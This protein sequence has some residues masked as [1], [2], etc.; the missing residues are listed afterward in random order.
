MQQFL[1]DDF[2]LETRFARTLYH[3]YA[4]EMPIFDYH[5][6]LNPHDIAADR[7]FDNL[8]QVW[9]AGDHY[10]WR[11][12]RTN[13][14]AERLITGDAGD[15]EKFE[16][17][18][19]TV[20]YTL[21]NPL[22][23]WTHM[24]LKAV[25]GIKDLL[26]SPETA[27]RIYD[28]C[29]ELLKGKEYSARSLIR[30]FNVKVICTTDDPV[31]D[32][33]AHSALAEAEEFPCR[34]LP[35]FRPDKAM[36]ADDP[37]VFCLWVDRL[38]DV[39]GTEIRDY[40]SFLTALKK[41]HTYF[42]EKGCRISD[43]SMMQPYAEDYTEKEVAAIFEKVRSKSPLNDEQVRKF[44]S[45][46]LEELGLMNAERDWAMQIHLGAMRNNNTKLFK[47]IGP[48]SG[49]DSMADLC[50]ALPLSRFLD[51]LAVQDALPRVILYNLNPRDNE[52]LASMIGN[53][54]D[55][56]VPGK[57]QLGSGWWFND[58]KAGMEWQMNALS[59]MGL[60]SRFVGMLTDSRSL[61][62]YPRHEYFRR[63]LCNLFGTDVE[64]G[65]LP[66]DEALVG[67]IVQDISYNNAVDYFKIDVTS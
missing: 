22:Y 17:W 8:T 38:A 57:I 34:V 26:L 32:L 59:N 16:A 41:R 37:G 14:I 31:D 43:H 56:S 18:A 51:R 54:Q 21:R 42:H 19:E 49:F 45:A 44:Q 40:R 35:T 20:P 7:R 6:H 61:L 50:Y 66:A 15:Y 13:G 39:S 58:Q 46:V 24:E 62:S 3:D 63:I 25:F 48:D 23:H 33:A 5:C 65:L 64:K 67:G 9:L 36:A 4:E 60:L 47:S 29:T 11:A 30:R 52:M 55:G 53:F 28:H 1:S 2:V 27:R 12:M 10:K